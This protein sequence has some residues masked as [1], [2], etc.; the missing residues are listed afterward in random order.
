MDQ[1]S[2]ALLTAATMVTVFV[3]AWLRKVP[4][5]IS[6][7]LAAVAGA[8]VAGYGFP[9]RQLVEGSFMFFDLVLIILTAT[10][11]LGA[12]RATGA[13]DMM[14]LGIIKRFHRQPLLLL[15]L[16]TLV[17]ML[18]GAL[19]G[20]GTAAVLAV[21]GLVGSV[22]ISL[23]IPVVNAVAIVAIA[24]VVGSFAPPVNIPAMAMANGIN[25]P[26]SGMFFAMTIIS[27]PLGIISSIAMGGRFLRRTSNIQEVIS[28]MEAHTRQ[29]KVSLVATYLPLALVLTLMVITRTLADIVPDLGIPLVFVIG[30]AVALLMSPRLNFVALAQNTVREAMPVASI[31]IGV[32]TFVQIMTL[33]GVRGLF[34]ITAVTLPEV[35]LYAFTLVGFVVAGALL[36][37]YGSGTVFGIPVTLAFLDRD[38]VLAIVGL[39]L[40][41]AFSSLTPPTAIVGQAAAITVNYKGSYASVIRKM[42]LPWLSAS[43]IG[44]AVV[45]FAD[46][47]GWL[48]RY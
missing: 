14:I 25:M 12:L 41:A 5:I 6:L 20:S 2:L 1:T 29:Q 13:L 33:T 43:L 32:G 16:L 10:L 24:G 4:H 17:V 36:G 9:L 35:W 22:L 18:P 15:S 7:S 21:G 40:M 38:P 11:F 39:S 42:W 44:L 37:S 26:Y 46:R 48:V 47:L 34:V 27:I 30:T 28:K 8:L 3:L 45:M 23:G 19:T 31:L